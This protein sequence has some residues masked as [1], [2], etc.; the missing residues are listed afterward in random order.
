MGALVAIDAQ[1]GAWLLR[2]RSLTMIL[3]LTR[4]SADRFRDADGETFAGPVAV[5]GT[6]A[7]SRDAAASS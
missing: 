6:V 3:P 7:P 2:E 4:E 1:A 5:I